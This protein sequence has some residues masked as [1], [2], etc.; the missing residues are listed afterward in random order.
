MQTIARL[1]DAF[2]S[3]GRY[4]E[5]EN[6]WNYAQKLLRNA[7]KT[8][9]LQTFEYYY[10]RAHGYRLQR[11]FDES[12]KI[13]RGLL[14]H[15]EK[16]MYPSM[17][18]IVIVEFTKVLMETSRQREAKAWLKKL[19]FLFVKGYGP[20]HSY[21]MSYCARVANC[22]A[23]LRR[24][25]E[26]RLYFGEVLEVLA[27]SDDDQ[28]GSRVKCIQDVNGWM[29]NAEK[30]MME[31]SMEKFSKSGNSEGEWSDTDEDDEDDKDM[32]DIFDPLCDS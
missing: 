23:G 30:M 15:H 24:H 26:A 11:R 25:H 19:Y 14:G 18:R 20:A 8:A 31:D 16:S 2:N 3:D 22:L 5:S 1:A 10:R 17:T 29:L 21:T 13:L 27:S 32:D 7:T 4:D 28:M 9:C 6:L 12:E